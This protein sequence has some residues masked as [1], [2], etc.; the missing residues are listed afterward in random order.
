MLPGGFVRRGFEQPD[1]TL[2]A[3]AR[4][5]FAEQTGIELPPVYLTQLR[6]SQAFCHEW[7]TISGLRHVYENIRKLRVPF[8]DR[9]GVAARVASRVAVGA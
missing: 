7:F 8:R 6:A 3:A 9:Q 2:D 1:E 5:V 4:R